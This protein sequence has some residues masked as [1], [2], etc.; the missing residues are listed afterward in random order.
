[1]SADNWRICPVCWDD[2]QNRLLKQK[3]DIASAYGKVPVAK[4]EA[5]KLAKITEP[6]E[7]FREDYEI[8]MSSQGGFY[9]NY[10]G[11]CRACGASFSHD[12][13]LDASSALHKTHNQKR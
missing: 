5:M 10:L 11:A 13:E 8:G 4:Y 1:M 9:V 6:E 3:A 2:Y 7:T 12:Q